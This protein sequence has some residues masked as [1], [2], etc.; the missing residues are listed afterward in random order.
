MLAVDLFVQNTFQVLVL[1]LNIDLTFEL[2]LN[3]FDFVCNYFD[4]IFETVLFYMK[5][6]NLRRLMRLFVVDLL[7]NF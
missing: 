1:V 5:V 2:S 3:L 6:V 7:P 4:S